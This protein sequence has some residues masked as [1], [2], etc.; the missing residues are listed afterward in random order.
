[1]K[2]GWAGVQV[3]VPHPNRAEF[4][5]PQSSQKHQ[6]VGQ[7]FGPLPPGTYSVVAENHDRVRSEEGARVVAG[8]EAA[9]ELVLGGSR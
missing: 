2:C 7:S 1:M 5:C 6:P 4:A 8:E 3:Q 9:V